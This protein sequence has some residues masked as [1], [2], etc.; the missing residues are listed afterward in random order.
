M[1]KLHIRLSVEVDVTNEEFRQ[2]A[3][4]AI[5]PFGG[6]AYDVDYPTLP[7]N[8]RNRLAIKDFKLCDW[9]EGG[10]IPD[11]WMEY[12]MEESGMY[13]C[14]EHGVRRKENAE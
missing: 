12:D 10:Y 9:D 13:E 6:G 11:S 4:E 7:I 2:I 1:P 14:D 3:E 8:V 5:M